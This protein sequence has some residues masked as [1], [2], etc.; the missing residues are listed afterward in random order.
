MIQIKINDLARIIVIMIVANINKCKLCLL[1]RECTKI[2][3]YE[4]KRVCTHEIVLMSFI[5]MLELFY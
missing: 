1:H 4:A 5:Y 3:E 2:C